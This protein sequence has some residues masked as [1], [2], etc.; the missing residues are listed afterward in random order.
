MVSSEKYT[1]IRWTDGEEV[2]WV[3][4]EKGDDGILTVLNTHSIDYR[5]MDI[6]VTDLV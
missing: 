5:C 4:T 6:D 3:H 1:A 2:Y